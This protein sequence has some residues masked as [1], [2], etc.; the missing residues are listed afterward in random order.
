MLQGD[1]LNM[2][3]ILRH[4]RLASMLILILFFTLSC[5]GNRPPTREVTSTTNIPPTTNTPVTPTIQA[6]GTPQPTGQSGNGL[7]LL[8]L[9]R[10]PYTN[11]TSKHQTEVEPATYAYGLTIIAAFQAGRFRDRG[12]SNI[13]WATSTDGGMTWKN[14]FLPG[15]T[16]LVGGRHDPITNP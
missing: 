13:G 1:S 5:A 9:S 4:S 16:K 3:R 6:N 8:Q 2:S 11:S 7:Q 14:G 12:A 15:T 10:D